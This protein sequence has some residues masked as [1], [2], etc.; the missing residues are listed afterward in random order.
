MQEALR[1]ASPHWTWSMCRYS[2]WMVSAK[3]VELYLMPSNP[4]NWDAMMMRD[5][6]D[7][8][9]LVTGIEIK[10]KTNP[11]LKMP[12]QS[13]TMPTR[14]VSRMTISTGLFIVYWSV[15]SAIKLVGP[16]DTSLI[17]PKKT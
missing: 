8:K 14:K 4:F 1:M 9:A 17:V 10:S 11:N 5:V 15:S 2:W 16:I 13:S 3:L 7:V 12:M 6:A